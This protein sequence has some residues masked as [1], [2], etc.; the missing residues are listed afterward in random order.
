MFNVS[1][2]KSPDFLKKLNI[3]ELNHL[4][5]DI[6][7]YILEKV[8]K[9]GGHLSSNLGVVELTVALHY[10]FNGLT[11]KFI[12]DVG[13]QAYTHKILTGRAKGFENLRTM[14]GVSGF[15]KYQESPYDAF[16]GGHSSTSISAMAGFMKARD[17]NKDNYKIISII[18]D[19]ALQNG[20]A[21]SGLNYLLSMDEKKQGII[22]IN[23][24][25]MA[26]SKNVGG[27][28]KALKDLNLS[29]DNEVLE[30]VKYIG[31]VDGH[32]LTK[33][34][35]V[36]NDNKNYPG[37]VV[38]HIKTKKGKGYKFAEEDNIG[39]YHGVSSFDLNTGVQNQDSVD[40]FS[41]I[42][43]KCLSK[44]LD[45]NDK[46]HVITPGMLY[47]TGLSEIYDKYKDRITDV[48]IQEE[49][50]VI[51]ASAMAKEGLIPFIFT[52]STFIQR[53]Y[54]EIN[55]DIARTNLHSVFMLDRAGVVP[56]DGD[57]HQGIFDVSMIMPI[58][59]TIICEPSNEKEMDDLIS[60][61][62]SN[63]CPIFIRYPKGNCVNNENN[64]QINEIGKWKIIKNIK[65]INIIS[66]GNLLNEIKNDFK[67]AIGE[68]E[69]LND[70]GIINSIF[71]KPMDFEVLKK[72]H[73][74]TIIVYEDC[75]EKASLSAEIIQYNYS[76]SANMN[77]ICYNLK[78]Y[79]ETGTLLEIKDKYNLN[80]VNLINLIKELKK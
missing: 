75:I 19:G 56:G 2:I 11:D 46:I 22:I 13:H 72:L 77:I 10:V 23:D 54:D 17:I 70:V 35:N 55:H 4:C 53:A 31:I 73:N 47:G 67:I 15:L 64:D 76:H 28:S 39:L 12:F 65:D 40:S 36:L 51:M 1:E 79:V 52:Y 42:A 14:N 8:S 45:M 20:V 57:T 25:E 80:V 58:P 50:A 61:S 69:S 7:K 33:L 59:N 74:K 24:N 16:E 48:G 26:I 78:D 60:L 62:I 21:L 38:I 27:V 18:G 37:L 3:E 49:N 5:D 30:G 71:L 66:Y 44:Y 29:I 6:R 68:D 63:K 9:N 43:C 32:N 41:N 34:I